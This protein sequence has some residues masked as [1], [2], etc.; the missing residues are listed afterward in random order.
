MANIKMILFKVVFVLMTNKK[1]VPGGISLY[2][3]TFL[4]VGKGFLYQT[5][6]PQ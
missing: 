2:S 5:S 4:V 6:L 1:A 3:I